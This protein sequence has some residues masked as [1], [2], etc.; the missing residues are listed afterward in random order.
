MKPRVEDSRIIYAGW[1]ARDEK[2]QVFE[3][4]EGIDE[5]DPPGFIGGQD[6]PFR[7]YRHRSEWS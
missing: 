4:Y 6:I 1:C 3:A 7:V 2:I 5:V